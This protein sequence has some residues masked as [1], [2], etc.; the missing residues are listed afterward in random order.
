[1]VVAFWEEA[2]LPSGV[3]GPV[4]C[5]ALDW[6]AVICAGVAI[7]LGFLSGW[8]LES[9][10]GWRGAAAV[11]HTLLSGAGCKALWGKAREA[12]DNGGDKKVRGAV[13]A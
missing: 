4:E 8:V 12:T 2:S 13:N 6:L 5:W 1:M 7:L 11:L 9:G 3:R 10:W